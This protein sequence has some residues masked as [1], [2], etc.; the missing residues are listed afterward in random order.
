M[1]ENLALCGSA[2]CILCGTALLYNSTS[3]LDTSAA[4]R[5]LGGSFVL[6]AGLITATLVLR[7]KLH[8]RRIRKQYRG[9]I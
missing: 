3:S 4:F 1:L 2:L 7:S 6:A 5:L 9:H 8:W